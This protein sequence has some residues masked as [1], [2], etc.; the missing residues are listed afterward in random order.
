MKKATSIIIFVATA[1]LLLSILVAVAC[2]SRGLEQATPGDTTPTKTDVVTETPIVDLGEVRF[3]GRTYLRF[4]DPGSRVLCY[5]SDGYTELSCVYTG[6][7]SGYPELAKVWN[8]PV[9]GD[10]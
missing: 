10:R 3:G 6:F 5:K 2:G 1:G 8:T 4:Y 9:E 7:S